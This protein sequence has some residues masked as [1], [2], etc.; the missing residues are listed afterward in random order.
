[1]PSPEHHLTL[2]RMIEQLD[3]E[4][5]MKTSEVLLQHLLQNYKFFGEEV[6]E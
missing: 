4:E 6:V 5:K 3:V 1:M 2:E